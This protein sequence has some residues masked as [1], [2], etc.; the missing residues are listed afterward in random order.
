MQAILSRYIL[1]CITVNTALGIYFFIFCGIDNSEM[2]Q[3]D[4]LSLEEKVERAKV[5]LAEKQAKDARDKSEVSLCIYFES[6][7]YGIN[8]IL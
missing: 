4:S 6:M 8:V 2:N 5:L 7:S 3:E 1:L